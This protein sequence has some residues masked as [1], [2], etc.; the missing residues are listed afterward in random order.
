MLKGIKT[1]E[2]D[3][4]FRWLE[5]NFILTTYVTHTTM[6]PQLSN[7]LDNSTEQRKRFTCISSQDIMSYIDIDRCQIDK[8]GSDELYKFAKF[9]TKM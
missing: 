4:D 3:A 1:S 9:L 8:I 5:P 6:M 7:M 2:R